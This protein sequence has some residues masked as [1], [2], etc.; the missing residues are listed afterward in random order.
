MT[1]R[2]KAS[3][4]DRA[5]PPITYCLVPREL[6][7]K[8]HE[9]LREHFRGDPAI[10]VVVERRS[11]ERRGGA[12]RRAPGVDSRDR[13]SDRRRIPAVAG[14][15][16][17]ERRAAQEPVDTPPLPRRLR[18]HAGRLEFVR[19]MVPSGLYEEDLDTARI[20]GRVQAGD[21]DGFSEIYLRY[22]ERVY[23]YLRV[24][25][26]SRHD[27]EDTAQQ[28]FAQAL[29]SLP[30]YEYRGRPFRAWLFTIARN[31]AIAVMRREGRVEPMDPV[32]LNRYLEDDSVK[33][34]EAAVAAA[35]EAELPALDWITDADLAIFME[36]MPDA[37]RQILTMRYVMGLDMEAIAE[38]LGKSPTAVRRAHSRALLFLRDRLTA[39]GR[40]PKGSAKRAPALAYRNQARVLRSRRYQLIDRGPVR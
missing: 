14:R 16:A 29:E 34:D 30:A 35:E 27:A 12:D 26:A 5:G 32:S 9:E 28:V 1:A 3:A 36:R 21:R 4:R 39:V 37:Q 13:M 17:G 20:V 19:R 25:L 22:F 15:R 2:P 6:A 10:E 31:C 7:G 33:I 38:S 11:A 23:G 18:R 24:A 40:E 8:L